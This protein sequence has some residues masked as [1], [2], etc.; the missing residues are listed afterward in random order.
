MADTPKQDRDLKLPRT[1]IGSR[2]VTKYDPLIAL[3]IVE[4]IAEG[5]LLR[6]I[7]TPENNMPHK[8]TFNRWVATQPELTKAYLAAKE[9]SALSFEEE[10]IH[11]ARE[12]VKD[13]GTAQRVGAA[14]LAVNQFRW[15]AS[16]RDPRNYGER[17][18]TNIVV[19]IHIETSLDMGQGTSGTTVD[20]PDIYTITVEPEEVKDVSLLDT[21]KA[22]PKKKMRRPKEEI[23]RQRNGFRKLSEFTDVPAI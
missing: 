8:S 17:G 11:M 23:E 16:R 5:K 10:A 20:M 18:N 4:Q 6:E 7:C 13:P 1:Q 9:L 15:S 19:P 2:F 3:E 12:L 21:L 22:M 14:N